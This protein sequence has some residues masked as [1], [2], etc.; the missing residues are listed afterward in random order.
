MLKG[1][2]DRGGYL[3]EVGKDVTQVVEIRGGVE[4]SAEVVDLHELRDCALRLRG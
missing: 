1:G 2:E 4:A 3:C